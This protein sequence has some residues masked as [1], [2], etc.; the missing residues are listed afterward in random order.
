MTDQRTAQHYAP[1]AAKVKATDGRWRGSRSRRAPVEGG[2]SYPAGGR[3]SPHT[4]QGWGMT[5][6]VRYLGDRGG[7]RALACGFESEIGMG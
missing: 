7:G 2:F 3:C 4:R 1:H 5:P 6:L